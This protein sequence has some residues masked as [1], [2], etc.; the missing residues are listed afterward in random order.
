MLFRSAAA[1]P[2]W[3]RHHGAPA[4]ALTELTFRVLAV[5]KRSRGSSAVELAISLPF[6]CLLI[7]G[8]ADIGRVFYYC[9]VV[10]NVS[11]E[12][13]RVAMAQPQQATGNTVCSGSGG[14]AS[15]ALP[16]SGG[17][18]ATIVNDAAVESSSNGAASGSAISGATVTVVWHCASGSAVTNST[19]GGVTDSVLAQFDAIE[20]KVLYSMTFVMPFA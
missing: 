8:A 18:I 6:L 2:V 11:R 19:S 16:A 12:A 17:S 20:V 4:G 1:I 10:V 3:S 9:E 5:G 13:L 15:S 14:T 7:F